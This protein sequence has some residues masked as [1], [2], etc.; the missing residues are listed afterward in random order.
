MK[1][2]MKALIFDMDGVIV[3]TEPHNMQQVYAYVRSLRPE[4]PLGEMYQIV[5]R[6]KK[7]V[8]TRIAGIIGRGKSWEETRRD[9]EENWKPSH[10]CPVNYRE[11]FRKDTLQI[12]Q[13]AKEQGMFTAVASATAYDK[14]KAILAEVGVLPCLDL[15]ISGESVKRSK[16][17]PEIYIK[18]AELLGVTPQECIAIE[19]S[20]VGITAAHRA[21]VKVVALIDDRFDF[22]RSL[23]DGEIKELRGFFDW[24]EGV[25]S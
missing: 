22:D 7:D 25:R 14:V 9:Y 1:V 21:G 20:T 19:D 18:A 24:V 11:I 17:D 13:W 2:N 23:A 4:V 16:P 5:G 8:W 3:D 12:L 15:I 10:P 6:T